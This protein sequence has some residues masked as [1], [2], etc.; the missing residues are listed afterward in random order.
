MS[1]RNKV[2]QNI[3]VEP[4]ENEDDESDV[5]N[6]KEDVKPILKTKKVLS[7]KQKDHLNNIRNKAIEAK[8]NQAQ[9]TKKANELK[10]LEK[11][12]KLNEKQKLADEYDNYILQ[13]KQQEYNRIEQDILRKSQQE[14]QQQPPPPPKQFQRKVKK[15]IYEDDE[16]EEPDYSKLVAMDSIQKL[17]QRALNERIFN[18][19][20]AYAAAMKPNYY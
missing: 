10:K 19:V 2:V 4:P 6:E 5:E 18:S 11:E 20:N 8:K 15:I 13:Q 1:K 12:E 17:H 14:Q 9:I 16:D 3:E 7:D